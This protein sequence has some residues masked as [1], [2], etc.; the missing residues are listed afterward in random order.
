VI[1][2]VDIVVVDGVVAAVTLVGCGVVA[3]CVVSANRPVKN[4]IDILCT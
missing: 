2:V 4:I 1:E 3:G